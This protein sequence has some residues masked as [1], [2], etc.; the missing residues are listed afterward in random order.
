VTV[1]PALATVLLGLGASLTWGFADFGGGLSSRRAPVFGVVLVVQAGGAALMLALA[2]L[3]GD[4]PPA[5]GTSEIAIACGVV[6]AG[7][8]LA[9]YHALAVG[10]MGVVAPVTAVLGASIPVLTGFVLLGPPSGS[11]MVGIGLGIAA[12]VLVSQVPAPGDLR[13]GIEW[14][15]VAGLL[16]GIFNVLVSRFPAGE[17]VWPLAIVRSTATVVVAIVAIV[18]RRPWR[19][20]RGA[21]PLAAVVAVADVI[22]NV[23]YIAAT[24]TGRLDVAAVVSSLYPVVTVVLAVL[25][26]R[27]RMTR[28]HAIG[29]AAAAGAVALIVAG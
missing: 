19:V 20:P 12:V 22:G 17:V 14:A 5:L 26:L 28:S 1:E 27:E 2:L 7:A 4:P 18:A 3:R 8:I 11:V 15:I 24:H 21:L 9:L 25:V 10:R 6:G 29:I 13:S 16:I 23:L